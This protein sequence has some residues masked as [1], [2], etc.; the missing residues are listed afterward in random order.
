MYR[1]DTKSA[2][3]AKLGN[4]G[5][6]IEIRLTAPNTRI[7]V[8]AGGVAAANVWVTA[9][10]DG[11]GWLGGASTN[12]EGVASLNITNPSTAFRIR[13][14]IGGNQLLGANYSNTQKSYSASDITAATSGGI[15][16]KTIPLDTPNFRVVVREPRADGSVGPIVTGNWVDMFNESSGEWIGGSNTNSN[17][18]AAFKV[19]NATSCYD[20]IYKL[21]VNQ[22]WSTTTNYSRQSYKL[23]I[24]CNGDITLT[25]ALTDAV[26]T[27]ELVGDVQAYTVTL[28]LPSITGVVVNPTN[29]PVPNSWIVPVNTTTY[30]WLWQIGSNSRSDGTFGISAPSGN[31]RIEA[32]VPYGLSDVAKPAPC[33]VN[34]ANGAVTTTAGGCVQANKSVVLALRAPN[35]S[36]TLKS[37]GNPV[38][39]ANVSF[40]A[41][42]WYT[43]A[44]TNSEGKVSFFIDAEEIRTMNGTSSA[45]PL[46]VW[47]DPPYSSSTLARWDCEAGDL[48]KPI[49]SGLVAI[50]ASGNYPEKLLG[51]VNGVQPNTKI[52]VLYPDT[53]AAAGAW[54][55]I[56]TIKPSDNSYGKRWLAAGGSDS[57]GYVAFNIDTLTVTSGATYVV[58]VN[59]P[60]NKRALFSSKE[61]TNAGAGFS[62]SGVNNQSFELASPNLKITVYAPNGIDRSKWGWLGIQEVDNSGNYLNWVGGY[63]LDDAAATSV[64]LAASKRYRIFVNPGPGRPGTQTDC[65][66]QTNVSAVVSQVSGGCPTGT[67][68]GSDTV[69]IS[70]NGGNVVGRVVRLSDDSNVAGAIVFANPVGAPDESG[71]VISC[72]SDEGLY[73][74]ELDKTKVWNIKIFPVKKADETELASQTVSNVQPLNSGTKTLETIKLANK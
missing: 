20:L 61:H 26:I 31:Y 46:R 44:Q 43:N 13:V 12:A 37:G 47:V 19:A 7:T 16:T 68:T 24:K 17:G 29:V 54:V 25:N 49:C 34:V 50:P 58:E 51:D 56:F 32:N 6:G 14:D 3:K 11:D 38:S 59:S 9:E 48:T 2:V 33:T 63:G 72:T 67:F 8:T 36:F 39:N 30:E 57:E 10:R 71:A 52:R 69:R 41:G 65:I 35:V 55:N 73:G 42:K 15:F 23:L 1:A 45:I 22:P 40:S 21:N 74:L 62:W 27:K 66:V 18:V 4:G 70:L 53:T 5:S 60:W 64:Y 28:G